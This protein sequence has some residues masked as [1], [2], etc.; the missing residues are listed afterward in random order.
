MLPWKP[1]SSLPSSTVTKRLLVLF[2]VTSYLEKKEMMFAVRE[3]LIIKTSRIELA[4]WGKDEPLSSITAGSQGCRDSQDSAPSHRVQLQVGRG[5]HQ[6]GVVTGQHGNVGMDP[7]TIRLDTRSTYLLCMF[8][9][10]SLA[11]VCI[12]EGNIL[13]PIM[14]RAQFLRPPPRFLP[15]SM[16]L[17]SCP[18]PCHMQTA[19]L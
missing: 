15:C 2:W 12:S 19:L 8:V 14:H 16:S 7:K 10:R 5:Q 11:S 6:E 4:G 17:L 1:N 18:T 9:Y 3:F 13:R